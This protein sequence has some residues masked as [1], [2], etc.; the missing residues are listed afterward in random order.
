MLLF[1]S[2]SRATL[3]AETFI[4]SMASQGRLT[5]SSAEATGALGVSPLAA[6]VALMRQ[7]EHGRI[8]MPYR[9]FY[10][11]VPPEYRRLGCLPPEQFIPQLMMHLRTPYYVGLL[12]AAQ[13]HGAAHQRPQELQVLVPKNRRSIV[14]GQVRVTFIA[15]K[16][17]SSVPT[18]TVRTPRGD[19]R[20]STPEATVLD[21]VGYPTHTGGLHGAATAV[22]ELRSLLDPQKLC[23]VAATAPIP[24][25]QRLGYLLELDGEPS[26]TEPL[27]EYV[28]GKAVRYV[29]LAAGND[30]EEGERSTRWRLI[31]NA[32][33]EPD[34]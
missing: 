8:A 14:C 25:A 34:V 22:L 6:R 1:E 29:P 9:G 3:S 24:W 28:R 12:S 17:L 5:F 19:L 15:R 20:I 11:I 16:S 13:Y 7:R 23:Q 10:V 30:A 27:A 4:E 21:L 18:T 2:K 32:E 31:L 33:V 26:P